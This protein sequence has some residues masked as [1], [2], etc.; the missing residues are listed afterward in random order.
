VLEKEKFD[1]LTDHEK[2]VFTNLFSRKNVILSPH[3]G[4]WTFSSYKRINE[5]LVGK[6]ASHFK[7]D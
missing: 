1:K 6:I 5:V 4:G 2:V 3:V 7:L